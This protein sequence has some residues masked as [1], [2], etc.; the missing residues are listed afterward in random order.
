MNEHTNINTEPL[1]PEDFDIDIII[2]EIEKV[3]P[4]WSGG[5]IAAHEMEFLISVIKKLR[6]QPTTPSD[7]AAANVPCNSDEA[8]RN[9]VLVAALP[10]GVMSAKD[11]YYWLQLPEARHKHNADV[12]ISA[13]KARDAQLSQ[14]RVEGCDCCTCDSGP[15]KTEQSHGP[16]Y[17]C[18]SKCPICAKQFG[19]GRGCY[20]HV[21]NF[22]KL[23]VTDAR[24]TMIAAAPQAS[25]EA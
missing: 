5:D 22:H 21:L 18:V 7:G 9:T 2:K 15:E 19:N 1:R 12:I 16:D 6:A 25:G 8:S 10:E 20:S 13:I 23:S 11:L 3:L 17:W 4:Y 14:A 24:K